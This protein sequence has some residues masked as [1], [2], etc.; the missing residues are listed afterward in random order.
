[1]TDSQ[2]GG[3]GLSKVR[4]KGFMSFRAGSLFLFVAIEGLLSCQ[5]ICDGRGHHKDLHLNETKFSISRTI[6][7]VANNALSAMTITKYLIDLTLESLGTV[8]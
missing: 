5:S 2:L 8:P 4:T 7:R 3:L 6:M 1:M